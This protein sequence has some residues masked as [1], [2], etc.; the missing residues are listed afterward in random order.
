M[1]STNPR[2][3][4]KEPR[5]CAHCNEP[6]KKGDK[7]WSTLK[8]DVHERCVPEEKRAAFAALDA[9]AARH[10]G[11]ELPPPKIK[12]GRIVLEKPEA[13]EPSAWACRKCRDTGW[14]ETKPD[15]QGYV[16]AFECECARRRRAGARVRALENS[17]RRFKGLSFDTYKPK[18]WTQEK[19]LRRCREYVKNWPLVGGR[20]LLLFG[21]PG[22][23]KSCLIKC[24]AVEVVKKAATE[25]GWY[26]APNIALLLRGSFD[27]ESDTREQELIDKL[28]G[29]EL[30]LLDDLGR[31]NVSQYNES[32]FF[33]FLN[34]RNAGMR[35]TL[36]TTNLDEEMTEKMGPDGRRRVVPSIEQRLGDAHFSR[37]NEMCD[38]VH[39]N[40]KDRRIRK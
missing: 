24:I 9:E 4:K 26:S 10:H 16:R 29:V 5:L 40:G 17:Q 12:L 18:H 3:K 11:H 2:R 34:R 22:V 31:E 13:F 7:E 20:G 19:A 30:L 37:L 39:V 33:E 38:F 23:G 14:G 15:A 21:P 32:V 1:T 8:G 36:I 28:G 6:F 27:K 25:I 35:P